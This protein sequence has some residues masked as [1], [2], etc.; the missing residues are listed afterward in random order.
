MAQNM[1]YMIS[2]L[3][4][5]VVDLKVVQNKLLIQDLY[6]AQIAHIPGRTHYCT[7][8]FF[9]D[10]AIVYIVGGNGNYRVNDGPS[11]PVKQGMILVFRPETKFEYGPPAGESWNEYYITFGGKRLNSWLKSGLLPIDE[12]VNVGL[13]EHII[14]KLESMITL[15]GSQIPSHSDRAAMIFENLVYEFYQRSNEEQA[16]TGLIYAIMEDIDHSLYGD[17]DSIAIAKRHSISIPTMRR[18]VRKKTGLSLH[19]YVNSQKMIE[20]KRLLHR[21]DT[22]INHIARMLGYDDPLY[23]SRLFKKYCGISASEFRSGI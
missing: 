17:F 23:F 21:S 8:T 7:N 18:L 15:L 3:P 13:D 2:T 14:L 5:R 6:I 20:A 16:R 11:H 19:N 10:W 9:Q 1:D 12:P 22:P 4:I